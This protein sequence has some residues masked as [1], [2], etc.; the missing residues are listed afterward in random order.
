MQWRASEVTLQVP[1]ELQGDHPPAY[2]VS[3]WDSVRFP[4]AVEY[5]A[6]MES[7]RHMSFIDFE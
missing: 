3:N 2:S 4:K 5:L 6:V 7:F 1:Q